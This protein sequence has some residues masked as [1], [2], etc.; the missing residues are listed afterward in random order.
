VGAT[1]G[2]G[3]GPAGTRLLRRTATAWS[4]AAVTTVILCVVATLYVSQAHALSGTRASLAER[5]SRL[6]EAQ[7]SNRTLNDRVHD[8]SDSAGVL[9]NGVDQ[10]QTAL[11]MD[12]QFIQYQFQAWAAM[13]SGNIA[14]LKNAVQGMRAL[15]RK[16]DS[17]GIVL[18]C[19]AQQG[20][21]SDTT[22]L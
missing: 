16:M 1:A 22:A 12:E 7:A 13:Q 3:P 18:K 17:S 15:G 10:C 20:A 14:A 8:L 19:L 11:R 9:A 6:A 2:P 21:T 4:A 5:S